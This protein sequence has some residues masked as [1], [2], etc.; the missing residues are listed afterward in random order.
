VDDRAKPLILEGIPDCGSKITMDGVETT[1]GEI[2]SP[3][4]KKLSD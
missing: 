2:Y 3:A 1:T 4:I